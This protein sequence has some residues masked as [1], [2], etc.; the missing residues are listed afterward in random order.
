MPFAG[1]STILI[2][3]LLSRRS[4]N[5][6]S[7]PADTDLPRYDQPEHQLTEPSGAN[8]QTRTDPPEAA[9]ATHGTGSFHA[10]LPPDQG[11]EIGGVSRSR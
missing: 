6:P 8:A 1:L 3:I 5:R 2:P 11:A 4:R 9:G 7:D 10:R